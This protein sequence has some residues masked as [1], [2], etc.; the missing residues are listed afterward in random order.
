LDFAGQADTSA[1]AGQ[2]GTLLLD[3]TNITVASKGTTNGSFSG[4]DWTS[5]AA[6]AVIGWNTI[7]SQ[8][9]NNAKVIIDTGDNNS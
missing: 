7:D 3:P 9:G 8:L 5:T 1:A 6:N 4:G 2:A